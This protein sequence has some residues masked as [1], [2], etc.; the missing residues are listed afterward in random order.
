MSLESVITAPVGAPFDLSHQPRLADT[1]LASDDDSL[2]VAVEDRLQ[3][4]LNG[5]KLVSTPN[6]LRTET[7]SFPRRNAALHHFT[8]SE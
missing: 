2:P 7:G 8:K 5:V 1:S 3:P 6:H 4:P